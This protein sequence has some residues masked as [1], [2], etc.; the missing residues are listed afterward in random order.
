MSEEGVRYNPCDTGHCKHQRRHWMATVQLKHMGL[1]DEATEDEALARLL[2]MWEQVE[3]D[4]RVSYASGQ[5]E[6]GEG[7]R[8]HGQCY[9]EFN[10]SLR[11]T[12]VRKVLPSRATHMRT[13]RT[14]CRTYCRKASDDKSYRVAQLPVLGVWEPERSHGL[15][16]MGPKQRCLQML[17]H[18]GLSPAEIASAD[19]DAYFTFHRSIHA[20][21]MA[22]REDIRKGGSIVPGESDEPNH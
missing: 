12:Q 8:L 1:D 20:L 22:M 15:D 7:G 16:Q 5:L 17:V 4:P 19:P 2:E 10:T 14:N 13:T 6:Q 18:E 3:N 11:N 9:V 21:W